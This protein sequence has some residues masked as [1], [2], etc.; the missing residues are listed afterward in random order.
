[1]IKS[2]LSNQINKEICNAFGC[3]KNATEKINVSAGTFGI[4]SL[5]LCSDCVS[6]FV[7][8]DDGDEYS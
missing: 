2:S 7:Q 5:D 3:S 8:K 6:N 4:I 1:M